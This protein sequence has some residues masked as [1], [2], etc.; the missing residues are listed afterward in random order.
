MIDLSCITNSIPAR[1]VTAKRFDAKASNIV[2]IIISGMPRSTLRVSIINFNLVFEPRV[3]TNGKPVWTVFRFQRSYLRFCFFLEQCIGHTSRTKRS[4]PGFSCCWLV[5]DPPC[6]K[7]SS[8]LVTLS[9]EY[10]QSTALPTSWLAQL[11]VRRC[12]YLSHAPWAVF[13]M[14]DV[15][16][17]GLVLRIK[18]SALETSRRELSEDVA[19]GIDNLLVVEQPS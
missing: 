14:L 13:S 12:V 5:H 15:S 11:G 19:F 9:G 10:G 2:N 18:R 1:D 17:V 4:R 8:K 3:Q 7:I 16:T 6:K